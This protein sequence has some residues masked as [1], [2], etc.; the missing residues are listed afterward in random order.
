M[1][2]DATIGE[3]CEGGPGR[4]ICLLNKSPC[5]SEKRHTRASISN[6]IGVD[7]AD[8]FRLDAEIFQGLAL[9]RM[10]EAYH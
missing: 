6:F 9:C 1:A 2:E 3:I 8:L 7:G 10:I 4:G 5:T